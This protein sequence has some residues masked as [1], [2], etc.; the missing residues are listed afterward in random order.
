[1]I[2]INAAQ[3]GPLIAM[4]LYAESV[5]G[6]NGSTRMIKASRSGMLRGIGFALV[7]ALIGLAT[8]SPAQAYWQNGIWIEPGPV[9]Y[10]YYRPP[11]PPVY[12]GYPYRPPAYYAPAPEQRQWVPQYWNGYRWVPGYWREY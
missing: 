12:G 9:P 6:L 4:L 3:W 11:P 10:P 1:L 7:V 8:R 2:Q 5:E